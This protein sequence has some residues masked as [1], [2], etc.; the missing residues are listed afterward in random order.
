VEIAADG[1]ANCS[2]QVSRL[3]AY[4]QH[5]TRPT[6]PALRE[7]GLLELVARYER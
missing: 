4:F 3:F 2:L 7:R 6:A 1:R 5:G